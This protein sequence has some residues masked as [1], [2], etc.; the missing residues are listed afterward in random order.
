MRMLLASLLILPAFFVN[1]DALLTNAADVVRATFSADSPDHTFDFTATVATP[2]NEFY[3]AFNVKDDSGY[4]NI[5]A[6]ECKYPSVKPG[7]RVRIRGEIY[8][9]PDGNR[10]AQAK[11]VTILGHGEAP[12]PVPATAEEIYR[13]EHIYKPVKVEGVIVDAFRDEADP[14]FTFLELACGRDMLY[15]PANSLS[16]SQISKLVQASVSIVGECSTYRNQGPRAKLGYEVYVF[17]F[18]DITIL[19]PPPDDPFLVPSFSESVYEICRPHPDDPFAR[20][21]LTGRVLAVWRKKNVLIQSRTNEFSQIEL[22]QPTPPACGEMIEAVGLPETDFYH[23][24]LSRAIWRAAK[25]GPQADA[26]DPIPI[27]ARELLTDDDGRRRFN[28]RYHGHRVCIV[29][30]ALEPSSPDAGSGFILEDNGTRI[31]IVLSDTDSV[32]PASGSKIKVTGICVMETK[33][34]RPQEPFPHITGVTIVP[35][36]TDDIVILSQ[37]PWWTTKLLVGLIASLFA[38][39]LAILVWNAA[40]R[41]VATQKGRELMREQLKHVKANLKTEER[42]RLAVELHDSLAQNLTGVSMEM[43]AAHDLKGHDPEGMS[44]HLDIAAKALKSCR[45]ELRNCLW[46][47]RSKALEEPTLDRAVIVTLQP[48]VNQSSLKVRITAPRSCLSDDATHALLS[49]IRELV[50]NAIRHGGASCVKI[51]GVRENGHLLC[52][53]ADNGK[54]FDPEN[55]PGVATGHFGLQGVNERIA[56]LGG[57]FSIQSAPGKGTHAIIRIRL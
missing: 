40:L 24:N 39:I 35:Q 14:R 48:H 36:R 13:G 11:S 52:S 44:R 49:A 12:K 17:S 27:A 53:V 29:G 55:A 23:L 22:S 9:Y 21:K 33:N 50:L 26:P 57:S 45:D 34:W 5:V 15:L 43:E 6:R 20:R 25:C 41:R 46:D 54:G 16:D 38:T 8:L 37:P 18:D 2:L 42:T 1:G 30:T 19:N 47:L 3:R 28:V 32:I 10:Y 4:A 51:A 56:A 31:P 7:D